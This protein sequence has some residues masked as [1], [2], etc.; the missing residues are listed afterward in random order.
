MKLA[1]QLAVGALALAAAAAHAG[2]PAADPAVMKQFSN[3]EAFVLSVMGYA[4]GNLRAYLASHRASTPEGRFGAAWRKAQYGKVDES[5][6]LYTSVVQ[7]PSARGILAVVA[8]GNRAATYDDKEGYDEATDR[9]YSSES[10]RRVF[11]EEQLAFGVNRAIGDEYQALWTELRRKHPLLLKRH[12]AAH[13]LN[14]VRELDVDEKYDQ[15]P[16]LVDEILDLGPEN[17]PL[18][19][20]FERVLRYVVSEKIYPSVPKHQRYG[21]KQLPQKLLMHALKVQRSKADVLER[22]N[23]ANWMR[24]FAQALY[25]FDT[26]H[27]QGAKDALGFLLHP[28]AGVGALA[29]FADGRSARLLWKLWGE[30]GDGNGLSGVM[31]LDELLEMVDKYPARWDAQWHRVRGEILARLGRHAAA[32]AA[33]RDSA[34]A[35]FFKPDRYKAVLGLIREHVIPAKFDF[36]RARVLLEPWANVAHV[37]TRT[38]AR[39]ELAKLAYAQGDMAR[40]RTLIERFADA[41]N[42]N[43]SYLED[44]RSAIETIEQLK[45]GAQ[46]EAA[47]Q[48]LQT[49]WLRQ[50][51]DRGV[52]V[53]LNFATNS[54]RLPAGAAGD[55]APIVQLFEDPQ[56]TNLAFRVEGHTD[57]TGNDRINDPLSRRRAESVARYL[58]E[59]RGLSRGRLRVEGYGSRRPTAS[60]LTKAGQ[61]QNRRVEV[62]LEGDLGRPRIVATGRMPSGIAATSSDGRRLLGTDATAWDTR[63][64]TRLFTVGLS[65]SRA[66]YSPDGRHLAI[67]STQDPNLGLVVIL[68]AETGALRHIVPNVSGVG[69]VTQLAW[70][71]DSTR[72]ALGSSFWAFVYDTVARKF[73]TSVPVPG[74][75][76]T[77]QIVWSRGGANLMM[78]AWASKGRVWDVD[79]AAGKARKIPVR[80]IGWLHA[81]TSSRDARWVYLSDDR[82]YLLSW[83]SLKQAAPTVPDFWRRYLPANRFAAKKLAVHPSNPRLVAAY[84]FHTGT[85]GVVD[86]EKGKV[87]ADHTPDGEGRDVAWGPDGQSLLLEGGWKANPSSAIADERTGIY[88]VPFD[89]R[90]PR[91][92]NQDLEYLTGPGEQIWSFKIAEDLRQV[93]TVTNTQ[94]DV[95]SAETGRRLH[96]WKDRLERTST[97]DASRPHQMVGVLKDPAGGRLIHYDVATFRRRELLYLPGEEIQRLSW[98]RGNYLAVASGPKGAGG[99]EVQGIDRTQLTL[100]VVDLEDGQVVAKRQVPV[101]T[102]QL[103][104]GR[105]IESARVLSLAL[106]PVGSE[107]AFVTEWKDHPR[108]AYDRSR[109]VRRW[110]WRADRLL[111]PLETNRSAGWTSVTYG[112]EGRLH[113]TTGNGWDH[114]YERGTTTWVEKRL[115]SARPEPT[116]STPEDEAF[117]DVGLKVSHKAGGEIFFRRRDNDQLVLTIFVKGDEWVAYNADRF[118]A[119]SRNGTEKVF[120]RVGARMLPLESM[121]ASLERPNLLADSLGRFFQNKEQSKPPPPPPKVEVESKKPPPVDPELFAIPYQLKIVRPKAGKTQAKTVTVEAEVKRL[122]PSAPAPEFLWKTNGRRPRGKT[123][124]VQAAGEDVFQASHQ[125]RLVPG[126]NV[127]T[128]ALRYKGA[129]ILPET[130]AVERVEAPRPAAQALRT[131]LWFFGVGV[132]EYEVSSQNLDFP[133]R[134]ATQLA[135]ALKAQEGKLFGKVHTK[136]LTNADATVRDIKIEMNRF[137]KQAS[138]Q[139]VVILFFAGHG[140]MGNDQELYFMAHDSDMSEAYTGFEL[141]DLSDYLERRPPSQKAMVL[142]D[143]CHAGSFGQ[144]SK[145]RGSGLTSE[146]AVR[147]VE[148]GTG[149]VVLASSTGRESSLED[150]KFRGGHGAFTAALLEGLEGKADREAGNGDGFI[151]V[152][153]LSSFVSREVP[154][155]T[156][157]AQHPTTPQMTN[158]RDFPVAGVR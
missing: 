110:D 49:S 84:C 138:S 146:E 50:H 4:R 150:P 90:A 54:D 91:C 109:K 95:F 72:L 79:L 53:R 13:L 130:V 93:V 125:F 151:S 18:E 73:A 101:A 10:I 116:W 140:V 62:N 132:K 20:D 121:R 108:Y 126:T 107:V 44:F 106:S 6:Q 40:A 14:R 105:R 47:D 45:K 66:Q 114:I 74:A 96:S 143:I 68:D 38:D 131:H 113:A 41:G 100:R 9:R 119:A 67:A 137:L 27:R 23:V 8:T 134:D 92:R 154:R 76:S 55:L 142:M 65:W 77:F 39:A 48:P 120:L 147:L 87:H 25:D 152:L 97:T 102:R 17:W 11:T 58:V 1:R 28:Q 94:V 52:S 61:R 80:G 19:F 30:A 21:R 35:A 78:G 156:D 103:M 104:S 117:A 51:G 83:D 153:E 155:L 29:L 136:V 15:I 59:D 122:H 157:G 111:D 129:I 16:P 158:L 31:D 124:E 71:P 139:D 86:F 128:V 144:T 69:K 26:R 42:A 141:R 89:P 148:E 12:R 123:P 112:P 133:D 75:M 32:E 115:N 135:A 88:T 34:R 36:A 37:G 3:H 149:T 98:C 22:A 81:I 46:Q 145:R 85:W 57:S 56:Y 99:I 5:V 24:A 7:D 2:V 60:N 63:T 33:Y 118:F 70:S 82:G 43:E 127:L 64:W